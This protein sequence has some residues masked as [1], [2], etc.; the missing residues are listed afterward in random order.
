VQSSLSLDV[1]GALS[2]ISQWRRP[3]LRWERAL[4]PE[5]VCCHGAAEGVQ[6]SAAETTKGLMGTINTLG[7]NMYYAVKICPF[8]PS[9]LILQG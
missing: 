6:K 1:S 5:H 8:I 3:L 4:E 2:G 9:G 7:S